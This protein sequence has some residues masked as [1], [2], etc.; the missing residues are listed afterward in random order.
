MKPLSGVALILVVLAA[1]LAVVGNR[2]ALP[3]LEPRLMPIVLGLLGLA[4]LLEGLA[5]LGGGTVGFRHSSEQ[6]SGLPARLWGVW[7]IV[8]GL[9]L[10]TASGASILSPGWERSARAWGFILLWAGALAGIYG[11]IRLLAGESYANPSTRSRLQDLFLR[12]GGGFMLLLGTLLMDAG[13]AL[14]ARPDLA[15]FFRR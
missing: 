11:A 1:A 14:I 12:L 4:A 9:G 2:Y 13:A 7:M 5:T 3:W 10:L 6:F 15:A 8:T